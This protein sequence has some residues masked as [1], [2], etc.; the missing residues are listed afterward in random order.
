MRAYEYVQK[1]E[2]LKNNEIALHGNIERFRFEI[3][4]AASRASSLSSEI[5]GLQAQIAAEYSVP[6]DENGE[7]GPDYGLIAGLEAQVSRYQSELYQAEKDGDYA[8]GELSAAQ[9][10]LTRVLNEK[11]ATLAEIQSN[12]SQTASNIATAGGMV[13]GYAGVGTSLQQSF[14]NTL[15]TLS[16]AA[17]II[18]GSVASV[19]SSSG[20]RGSAP[21]SISGGSRGGA[22]GSG[23]TRAFGS[24]SSTNKSYTSS[25]FSSRQM[26][27]STPGTSSFISSVR[28]GGSNA[29]QSFTSQKS[30]ATMVSTTFQKMGTNNVIN[31][32]SS[33]SA[34]HS[35]KSTSGA[36]NAV[37]PT[38]SSRTGSSSKEILSDYM[39]ANNYGQGD[40]AK[41]S[42]DPVWQQLHQKAFPKSTLLQRLEETQTGS[43]EAM[44]ALALYM[45]A[46][47]YQVDDFPLY[48][49]DPEWQKLHQKAFPDFIL[50]D[51][52][53]N[54]WKEGE[55]GKE[56]LFHYMSSHNYGASD[57]ATYSKDVQWQN[58]H[59]IAFP[60]SG[61]VG[62]L[63]GSAVA[64]QHLSGYMNEHNYGASDFTIYSQDPE[65]QNLHN[66]AYP[67]ATTTNLY[68]SKEEDISSESRERLE[69]KAKSFFATLFENLD[70]EENSSQTAHNQLLSVP[71]QGK[72][73]LAQDFSELK[74]IKVS[75]LSVDNLENLTR[76]AVENLKI[77][78]Q[79]RV[80]PH[81][82]EEITG[83]I[84]FLSV[85]EVRMELGCENVERYCGY[86]RPDIDVIRVNLGGNAMVSDILATIDHEALHFLSQGTTN[87]GGVMN[88][89]I[90]YNNVGMN[91]GIT[92]M[93][94]IKNM[95]SVNPE[96][97]SNS[98]RE[99]VNI[100]SQFT[101]ICGET[102]ILDAYL[103]QDFALLAN[104]FNEGT[105]SNAFEEFCNQLDLF[106]H[107]GN[108]FALEKVKLGLEA[109]E[110]R[111]K[112]QGKQVFHDRKS[113][114]DFLKVETPPSQ[115]ISYRFGFHGKISA[116]TLESTSQS[117]SITRRNSFLQEIY[118]HY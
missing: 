64:Q 38:R 13:G 91:E 107:H 115:E 75:D 43:P 88:A 37:Y 8:R 86:Y 3:Q 28:G 98:Y 101:D 110:L 46:H 94:S 59:Q 48:S 72:N 16:T 74:G 67:L 2:H 117:Q 44:E 54:E 105:S 68:Q 113:F 5:S 114:V 71:S 45:N 15:S 52:Q 6:T 31:S 100:M 99:E 65:W 32:S 92:E 109:Y 1:A 22:G 21:I 87:L 23:A 93:L 39:N 58:L 30:S 102:L 4:E 97:H 17:S 36:V 62:S 40:F 25:N 84:S 41:Y 90:I 95:R 53:K 106:H 20:S 82:L 78:Y 49:Q 85:E 29:P 51:S 73:P 77:K 83:R 108:E 57:F 50:S 63:V 35:G 118:S 26:G 111:K 12:A 9:G 11:A 34:Y 56:A 89:Q 61:F 66:R 81:R 60:D 47:N 10:E 79:D 80:P 19:S 96:Y 104:D 33:M 18:G 103:Q 116:N 112:T 42:K 14:Q 7:G 55:K 27:L 76:I 24:G 70:R 69:S